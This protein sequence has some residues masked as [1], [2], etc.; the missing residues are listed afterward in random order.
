MKAKGAH[1][2]PAYGTPATRRWQQIVDLVE[3]V[4]VRAFLALAALV[5]VASALSLLWAPAAFPG[6]VERVDL[7]NAQGQ[8]AGSAVIDR[9]G[10]RVD[11]YDRSSNRVGYGQIDPRSGR[12]DV[13]RLDGRRSGVVAPTGKRR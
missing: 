4:E 5:V 10:G 12:V 13:F 6:E 7:Y 3:G 9:D 2:G 8:R 11:L 1:V